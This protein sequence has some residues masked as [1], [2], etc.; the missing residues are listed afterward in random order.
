LGI[1]LAIFLDKV[2]LSRI[3]NKFRKQGLIKKNPSSKDK[4]LHIILLTKKG[5]KKF[6]KLNENSNKLTSQLIKK[7]S[8]EE[9]ENLVNMMEGI[10]ELLGRG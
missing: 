3:I 7:L 6:S 9:R 10:R 1:S 4:R 2:Q 8:D 5:Q